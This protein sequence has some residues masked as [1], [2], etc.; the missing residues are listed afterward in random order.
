[1]VEFLTLTSLK[2]GV[3]TTDWEILITGGVEERDLGMVTVFCHCNQVKI[4]ACDALS[5]LCQCNSSELSVLVV[6]P[7]SNTPYISRGMSCLLYL[8]V[9]ALS[10]GVS[11]TL[12]PT[13][14]R[15][16]ASVTNSFHQD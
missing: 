4:E 8:D 13:S 5:A 14:I 12:L 7:Y 1:M 10:G 2:R 16:A 3:E 9:G 6:G 11:S 15:Q